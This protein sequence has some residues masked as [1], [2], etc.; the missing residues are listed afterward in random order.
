MTTYTTTV[1]NWAN[2]VETVGAAGGAPILYYKRVLST[3]VPVDA[4][5]ALAFDLNGDTE[6]E[7]AVLS[8]DALGLDV[9][10]AHA[11]AFAE[12]IL[13]AVAEAEGLLGGAK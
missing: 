5:S 6:T 2:S 7:G 13:A 9:P 11:R 8:C 12:A 1:P 10:M 3:Q 4:E